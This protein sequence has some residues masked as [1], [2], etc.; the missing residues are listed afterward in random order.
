MSHWFAEREG[1]SRTSRIEKF[2]PEE[3]EEVMEQKEVKKEAAA[4]RLRRAQQ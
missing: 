2:T 4:S 1:S 3:E